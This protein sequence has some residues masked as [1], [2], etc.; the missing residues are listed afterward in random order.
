MRRS[1]PITVSHLDKKRRCLAKKTGTNGRWEPV[2]KRGNPVANQLEPVRARML[3]A[4]ERCSVDARW[5]RHVRCCHMLIIYQLTQP[6][7][8]RRKH[9]PTTP[10]FTVWYRVASTG[11]VKLAFVAFAS[12]NA[13]L[14]SC[15]RSGRSYEY[16]CTTRVLRFG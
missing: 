1:R 15:G 3:E 7:R 4:H 11:D 13:G 6:V 9:V 14:T 2:G 12:R 8:N 16:V 10:R 5:F